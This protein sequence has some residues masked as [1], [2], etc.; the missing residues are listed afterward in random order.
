MKECKIGDVVRLKS[1]GPMMT[2]NGF[3]NGKPLCCWFVQGQVVSAGFSSAALFSKD[4]VKAQERAK[5]PSVGV[6]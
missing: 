3:V 1:G 5:Q 2:V 4:E 6:A